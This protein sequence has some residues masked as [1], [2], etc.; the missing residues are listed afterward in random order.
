MKFFPLD[1]YWK[2]F[3]GVEQPATMANCYFR[4]C[5]VISQAVLMMKK[6]ITASPVHY[7]QVE[8]VSAK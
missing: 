1:M 6:K 5:A 2:I 3:H 7:I 8:D 4:C